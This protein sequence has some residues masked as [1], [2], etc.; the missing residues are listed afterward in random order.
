MNALTCQELR[1]LLGGYVL[2]ALEPDE[3][4]VR[5][6]LRAGRLVRVMP[7]LSL[8]RGLVHAVF[9]SRRGMVPAVRNFLDALVDGFANA[10]G[11]VADFIV[12]APPSAT[13]P[14]QLGSEVG[15]GQEFS[16]GARN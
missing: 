3:I 12:S 5:A 16:G 1:P 10:P 6:D 14:T 13:W 8:S 15:P 7:Q 2:E 11:E 4:T 9:P